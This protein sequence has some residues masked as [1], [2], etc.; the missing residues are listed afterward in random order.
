MSSIIDDILEKLHPSVTCY[1]HWNVI[2]TSDPEQIRSDVGPLA[3]WHQWDAKHESVANLI[4]EYLFARGMKVS[5][6]KGFGGTHICVF[7][8]DDQQLG[9]V[10]EDAEQA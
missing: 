8:L 9:Y 4:Q 5:G 2:V 10:L 3:G 6:S 1:G 7:K